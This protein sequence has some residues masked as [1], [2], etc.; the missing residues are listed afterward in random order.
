[1]TEPICTCPTDVAALLRAHIED[2]LTCPAHRPESEAA[3]AE[4][5]ALNSDAL[6]QSLAAALGGSTTPTL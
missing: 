6:T 2:A 3:R 4:P 1:M 5:P